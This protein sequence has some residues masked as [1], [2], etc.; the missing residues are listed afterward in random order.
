MDE[1]QARIE[2]EDHGH[3]RHGEVRGERGAHARTDD[4]GEPKGRDPHISSS[5]CEAAHVGLDL[6]GVLRPSRCRCVTRLHV[7]REQCRVL[8]TGAVDGRGGLHDE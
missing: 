5:T 8:G 1:L 7:L 2:A 4:I 3:H 6:G